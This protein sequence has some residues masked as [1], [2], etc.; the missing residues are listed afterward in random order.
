MFAP[1]GLPP[2]DVDYASIPYPAEH[3]YDGALRPNRDLENIELLSDKIDAS[4][5][6]YLKVIKSKYEI[7]WASILVIK[8]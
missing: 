5:L 6:G 8:R 4:S 7:G 2:Y 1:V 3:T